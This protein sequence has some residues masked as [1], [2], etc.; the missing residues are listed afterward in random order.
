MN[1][2]IKAGNS[3][4]IWE[5]ELSNIKSKHQEMT[6]NYGANNK[7]EDLSE[8]DILVAG[9]ITAKEL[10]AAKQLKAIFVPFTGVNQLPL[11]ELKDRNISVFNSHVNAPYIAEKALALALSILGRI[12]EL[13][14]RLREK[15]WGGHDGST[16]WT[17]LQG[18]KCGIL[19]MGEIGQHIVKLLEPFNPRIVT[20]ERYNKRPIPSKSVE[21]HKTAEEVCM[22]SDIVF[23]SLPS[24]E[25]TNN[26]IDE[27]VLANMK[28]KFIVNVGRA[29]VVNEKGLY[30]S[31]KNQTLKGAAFDVWYQYRD[32]EGNRSYPSQY[33][34]HELPNFV[35]SPHCSAH[36]EGAGPRHY[37]D[38]AKKIGQYL[39]DKNSIREINT[40][41][42]Y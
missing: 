5:K 14:H 3:K 21:F 24:T 41:L 9:R 31:L 30:N 12:V 18:M 42:G 4:E 1:I 7:D 22:T 28:G 15:Q 8:V 26:M 40:E 35:L 17:S 36:T 29:N 34:L 16:L 6:I 39:K 23:I 25:Q 32:K 13:D 10:D 2:F 38:T 11:K 20:M 27:K 37:N 33:P 19:G